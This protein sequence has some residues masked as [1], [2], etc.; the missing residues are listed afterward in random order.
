MGHVLQGVE[1]TY[2]HVTLPMEL[3][4]AE[5]LQTLWEESQRVVVD[6]REYGPFPPYAPSASQRRNAR[7]SATQQ[8]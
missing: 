7:R 2:S 3:K 5:T 8:S 1:G 6:R 4:I